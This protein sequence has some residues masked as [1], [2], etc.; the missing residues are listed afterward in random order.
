MIEKLL[1]DD[2]DPW[3]TDLRRDSRGR[4]ARG[5]GGG[6]GGTRT[7]SG[8]GG[9]ARA[10]KPGRK[11]NWGSHTQRVTG[12]NAAGKRRSASVT[13]T[14]R[15]LRAGKGKRTTAYVYKVGK[16]G[17][18]LKNPTKLASRFAAPYHAGG[19]RLRPGAKLGSKNV[20]YLTSGHLA[21]R[22]VAGPGSIYRGGGRLGSSL[23][24]RAARRG[25]SKLAPG[26]VVSYG[27]PLGKKRGG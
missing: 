3:V 11:G 26:Y 4:F 27:K 12:Y 10:I 25:K 24:A 14:T 15:S 8:G 22:V 6:G 23:V 9:G 19:G 1:F 13:S 18:V 5:G 17:R 20:R 7:R 21:S 16:G 2:W